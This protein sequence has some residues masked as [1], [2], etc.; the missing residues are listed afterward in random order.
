[1]TAV[2][3][4]TGRE[5]RRTDR[6]DLVRGSL[7]VPPDVVTTVARRWPQRGDRWA[8][9]VE[10]ELP[11]LCA[12]YQ[13]S[14]RRVLPARHGFVV[15][16]DTAHGGIV[17][18]ASPDPDAPTQAEVASALGALGV[19]PAVH[20]IVASDD[21]TWI[22][23]DQVRPGTPLPHVDQ[24]AVTIESLAAPLLGMVGRPAPVPG[25]P[26]IIDWLRERLEDDEL[27][28]LAPGRTIAPAE[29]RRVAIKALD[30]LAWDA[31]PGLCHAD[32]STW[33]VL[34]HG[35]GEWKLIDPR[36]MSGEVAYD[37]AVLSL[38]IARHQP[39]AVVA[40]RLAGAASIDP[41]RA[42]AWVIVAD[43]ARV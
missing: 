27:N 17:F 7:T 10:R 31:T 21:H 8:R 38:K 40:A 19:A 15:A 33:N 11:E 16:A 35:Q 32:V 24:A 18:R 29:M 6:P 28:D 4:P 26:S 12:R 25:M 3:H 39:P 36:G 5:G 34:A 37:I 1:V 42:Q 22:V 14:P 30:G 41:E 43:A 9:Q 23:L 13:A 2:T 20:E